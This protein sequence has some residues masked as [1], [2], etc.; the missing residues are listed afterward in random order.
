MD[1]AADDTVTTRAGALA[2]EPLQQEARQQER[3]ELVDRKCVLKAIGG[4]VAMCPE[5]ADVVEQHVQPGI[6]R[7]NLVG[8]PPD[9]GLRRHVGDEDVHR[10]IARRSGNLRG[11]SLGPRPVAARDA[12]PGTDRGQADGCRPADPAR[13]AGDQ[14][15][16]ARHR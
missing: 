11:G 6:G 5:S 15:G 10:R 4:H 12:H 14:H 1:W 16:L 9:L 7:Q 3:R 13:G 8:Q 2:I